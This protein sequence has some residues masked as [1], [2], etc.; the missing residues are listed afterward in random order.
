MAE[1]I[2]T[3]M[4]KASEAPE[5]REYRTVTGVSSLLYSHSL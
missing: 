5:E 1:I 3:K 2:T 4:P